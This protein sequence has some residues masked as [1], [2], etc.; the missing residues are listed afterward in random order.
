MAMQIKRVSI[1]VNVAKKVVII[2]KLPNK[3]LT[4]SIVSPRVQFVNPKN[5]KGEDIRYDYL[6]LNL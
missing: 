4:N 2:R 6:R 1:G 3:Y 5:K